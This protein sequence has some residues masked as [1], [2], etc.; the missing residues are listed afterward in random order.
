MNKMHLPRIS[1]PHTRPTTTC[2]VHMQKKTADRPA[3]NVEIHAGAAAA[4]THPSPDP[5]PSHG[6]P[7]DPVRPR[8][9]PGSRPAAARARSRDPQVAR[10]HVHPPVLTDL[11][12]AG[13]RRP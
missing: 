4:G 13:E 5:G 11:F 12:P 10:V 6:D 2:T 8:R 9:Y 1:T 7:E 3:C